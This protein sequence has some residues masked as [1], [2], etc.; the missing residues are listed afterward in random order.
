[1]CKCS[2]IYTRASPDTRVGISELVTTHRNRLFSLLVGP[3][4]PVELYIYLGLFSQPGRGI[5]WETAFCHSP[6]GEVSPTL[7]R[8]TQGPY[9]LCREEGQSSSVFQFKSRATAD[10]PAWMGD[11]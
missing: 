2:R 9:V 10:V 7:V 4:N 8:G 1:M 3:G 5:S 11:V 6:R